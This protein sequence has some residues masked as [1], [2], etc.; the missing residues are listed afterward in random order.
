MVEN[1]MVMIDWGNI[2]VTVYFLDF[3]LADLKEH[4]FLHAKK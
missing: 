2:C 1:I 3:L 4:N